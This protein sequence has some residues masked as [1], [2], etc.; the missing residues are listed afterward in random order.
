MGE[1]HR[2]TS[3]LR[4]YARSTNL[5]L[6][7]GGAILLLVVGNLLVFLLYDGWTALQSLVCMVAFLLP[8]GMIVVILWIMERIVRADRN[9]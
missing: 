5:R 9:G 4:S 7:A 8:L 3:D 1:D 2:K 6:I